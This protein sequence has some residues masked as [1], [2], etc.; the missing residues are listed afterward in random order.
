[1]SLCYDSNV[2]WVE[3]NEPSMVYDLADGAGRMRGW[4]ASRDKATSYPITCAD[5]VQ[6]TRDLMDRFLDDWNPV[7]PVN[8]LSTLVTASRSHII[9]TLH[10]MRFL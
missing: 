9:T 8:N 5:H 7:V 10:N 4:K 2:C 6:L 3:W 1:M